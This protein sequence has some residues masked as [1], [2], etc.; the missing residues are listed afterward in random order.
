MVV[1]EVSFRDFTEGNDPKISMRESQSNTGS[2][3]CSTCSIFHILILC[4]SLLILLL[5]PI[6]SII[7]STGAVMQ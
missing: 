2:K 5:F 3:V 7:P 1:I 4:H 6:K